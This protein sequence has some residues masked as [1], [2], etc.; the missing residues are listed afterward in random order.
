MVELYG[1]F[2]LP[3]AKYAV[4]INGNTWKCS[5]MV[6]II[7]N[8]HCISELLLLAIKL[9]IILPLTASNMPILQFFEFSAVMKFE[10]FLFVNHHSVVDGKAQ[11]SDLLK[12]RGKTFTK[13][14]EWVQ[15][16]ARTSNYCL[17][18]NQPFVLVCS[19]LDSKIVWTNL[20]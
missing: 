9:A 8:R 4:S 11:S 17:N 12:T 10:M 13:I 6:P 3:S 19:S 7:L 5:F 20:F 14:P 2:Q 15:N 16:I 18:Y 1:K